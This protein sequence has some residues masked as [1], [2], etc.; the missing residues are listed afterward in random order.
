MPKTR[1][2][3]RLRLKRA[4]RKES[5]ADNVKKRAKRRAASEPREVEH[6][7][8]PNV[9]F[10][11]NAPLL[12]TILGNDELVQQLSGTKSQGL[13]F[14]LR[15][16]AVSLR[17][18][19][20]FTSY[21]DFSKISDLV[22]F[23]NLEMDTFEFLSLMN[24][25]G[26]TKFCFFTQLS[27]SDV[28]KRIWKE[29]S[30]SAHVF[31]DIAQL[32]R[33]ICRIKVR[34]LELKSKNP[35]LFVERI[36]GSS[37]CGYV[38]GGPMDRKPVYIPGIGS[39]KILEIK[40]S[41][42]PLCTREAL[43]PEVV[44]VPSDD[45]VFADGENLH[46]YENVSAEGIDERSEF[47][48][49]ERSSTLESCSHAEEKEQGLTR[50]DLERK[51]ERKKRKTLD[52]IK[53]QRLMFER[54]AENCMSEFIPGA[55]VKVRVSHAI[56]ELRSEFMD[57]GYLIVGTAAEGERVHVRGKV[58][59]HKWAEC[60]IKSLVP[61]T[62]SL[63][64]YRF[65]CVPV[66][67]INDGRRNRYLKKNLDGYCDMTFFGPPECSG[68][69]CLVKNEGFRI[70]ALGSIEGQ[71][72]QI[73]KKCKLIGVSFR[74]FQN[75]V[76][77]RHMFNTREEVLRFVGGRL[78]SV[79]GLRG[80]IKRPLGYSG[81]FRASF[82]GSL[83]K[84]DIV[85]LKCYFPTDVPEVYSD[86]SNKKGDIEYTTNTI[87]GEMQKCSKHALSLVLN[88][89]E[90]EKL[91]EEGENA[92]YKSETGEKKNAKKQK[93]FALPVWI[94]SKLPLD[95]REIVEKDI[96]IPVSPE[97]S[98]FIKLKNQVSQF[99]ESQALAEDQKRASEALKKEEAR[100]RKEAGRHKSIIKTVVDMKKKHKRKKTRT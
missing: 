2:G 59:I 64:W 22:I 93:R 11:D 92:M 55:Y 81:D 63:G 44:D 13:T 84:N 34:P 36:E 30:V 28:K 99:R 94:E 87:D 15:N 16:R 32:I 29:V 89:A 24:A 25:H 70:V 62:I 71:S 45:E 100:K 56:G 80:I 17:V 78:K 40:K 76:F 69:F 53:M 14:R 47:Y 57:R 85:F 90:T 75:S 48:R 95:M 19:T 60:T 83:N 7:P 96:H 79:S 51:Y 54:E 77:I 39:C 65:Q 18:A 43:V 52:T 5:A 74:V 31:K 91:C 10:K 33:Y 82:E 9:K 12:V 41:A 49:S 68:R 50:E 58:K 35:F 4:D 6:A 20:D 42:D 66:L 1:R 8:L 21:I 88:S 3:A 73:V 72:E 38:R 98:E 23:N 86:Y 61:V 67:S 37:L 27:P 97:E 46:C 26:F